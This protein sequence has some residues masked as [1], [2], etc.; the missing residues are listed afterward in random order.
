MSLK[1]PWLMVA[2]PCPLETL[3][4]C[5]LIDA[6]V[7]ALR[8]PWQVMVFKGSFPKQILTQTY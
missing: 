8:I 6:M 1:G 3:S 7:A 4:L 2:L 5:S